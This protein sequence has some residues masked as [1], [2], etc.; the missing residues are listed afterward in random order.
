MIDYSCLCDIDSI[1]LRI[2]DIVSALLSSSL[3]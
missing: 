3:L 2:A 1:V